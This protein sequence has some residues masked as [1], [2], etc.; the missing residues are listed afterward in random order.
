MAKDVN[1]DPQAEKLFKNKQ[2]NIK[3]TLIPNLKD[4]NKQLNSI[5]KSINDFLDKKREILYRLHFVSNEEMIIIL[6]R[7]DQP[8]EV[9]GFIGKLFENIKC[10]DFGEDDGEA[11]GTEFRGITSREGETLKFKAGTVPSIKDNIE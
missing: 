9:Q 3:K 4:F 2:I 8:L 10:L 7:S 1:N 6:A 11:L 5:N